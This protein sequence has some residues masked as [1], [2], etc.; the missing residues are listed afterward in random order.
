MAKFKYALFYDFHT[1]TTIPDVGERF[2]VERFTDNVKAC[3]VDFLTWHARCNQGNAY[4]NTKIGKRH[5]SLKYDMFGELA[6]SC[7]RKGIRLSAY[8]NGSLSDEEALHHREW[9]MIFTDGRTLR[10]PRL[11]PYVRTLC[12]NSPYREHLRDMAIEVI[13]KYPVDGLF[14]DCLQKFPCVCE[15]C[16]PE[17]KKMGFDPAK[18]EDALEFSH[19]SVN[20]LCRFL[21][22]ALK[23][24]K[25]DLLLF[26][27]NPSFE[28]MGDMH[29]HLECECLPTAG[30]GYEYL[31]VM[32]HYMRTVAGPDRSVLNMTGRFYDW[33]DFGGLRKEAGI[34]YDLFYGLANG[35]RPD[36]G[37]HFHPRGDM[38]QPVF[39]LIR[40]LYSNL[41]Q[42]D[43]WCDDAVNRPEIA[44]VFPK[45]I[46]ALRTDHS[47]QAATRML[48]ELKLQFDI[49]TEYTSWDSY[50]LLI[51]PDNVRISKETAARLE[52]YLAKG[53]AVI[54]SAYSGLDPEDKQFVLKGWP[55]EYKGPTGHDPLYFQPE[56][57]AAAGLPDMPLSIYAGGTEVKAARG[58]KVEMYCVKPYVNWAWDGLRSNYYTPPQEKTDE[59]FLAVKGKVAYVCGEIFASYYKLAP[60]QMRVLLGNLIGRFL[61]DP[62]FKSSTLPSFTRAFVQ[63]NKNMELVHVLAYAPERRGAAVALEDRSTLVNTELSLRTDGKKVKKVYLAPLRGKLPFTVKDGYCT[64]NVPMIQGYSLVVFEY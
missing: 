33:G 60:Y 42:Y 13:K 38:D 61:P 6:K 56:G 17:M 57:P 16:A 35:M 41:Q 14:F 22:D 21:H 27:N 23:E 9:M 18:E 37:G 24:V 45:S 10:E 12:Y 7:R 46:T 49:V 44:V 39:D 32:A 5:P 48:T 43:F 34:E 36:V 15:H 62:K 55:V 50:R 59:P 54:A 20:R 51:L 28:E 1:L 63:E 26:F 64:V 25:P 40:S 30:W 29:S 31:P 58:A 52:K 3:G 8:I 2:D 47:L 11:T 4:Y 19:F 53:G